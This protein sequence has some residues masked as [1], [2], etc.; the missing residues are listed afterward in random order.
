M[1]DVK[2]MDG[3]LYVKDLGFDN[4]RSQ[5]S[6]ASKKAPRLAFIKRIQATHPVAVSHFSRRQ[7]S[8]SKFTGKSKLA[9]AHTSEG[10]TVARR[11]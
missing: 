8:P 11:R 3:R 6:G 2:A 9:V 10:P 4:W 7:R 5:E 1:R